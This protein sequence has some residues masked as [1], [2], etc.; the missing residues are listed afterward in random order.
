MTIFITPD[1]DTQFIHHDRLVELMQDSEPTQE[2]LEELDT[3]DID[4]NHYDVYGDDYADEVI[5]D[6]GFFRAHYGEVWLTLTFHTILSPNSLTMLSTLSTFTNAICAPMIV[7]RNSTSISYVVVDFITGTA[8]VEFKSGY[9]YD[10]TNVSRRAILNLLKTKNISAG[11]WVNNEL[12]NKARV[13]E[14]FRYAHTNTANLVYCWYGSTYLY[15]LIV[16]FIL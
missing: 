3:L 4:D 5:A 2:E 14:T 6:L 8:S 10:Y 9:R 13:K 1:H 7:Q 12:L 16:L 11:F 15:V